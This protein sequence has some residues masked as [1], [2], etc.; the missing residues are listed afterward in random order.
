[1]KEEKTCYDNRTW[2]HDKRIWKVKEF[3][4][5]SWRVLPL[6][7]KKKNLRNCQ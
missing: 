6:T 3:G 2:S 4:L 1:M 7:I 5:M